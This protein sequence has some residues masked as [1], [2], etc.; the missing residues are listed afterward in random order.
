MEHLLSPA[1]EKE[2]EKKQ[3]D[4][5]LSLSILRAFNRGEYDRFQNV[6]PG[7]IPSPD[8]RSIIDTTGKIRLKLEKSQ[9]RRQLSGL[10]GH[11]RAE[12]LLS[13]APSQASSVM[14]N[15]EH[16]RE[17]GIFLLPYTAYGILNGGSATSYLDEQKNSGFSPE[18]FQLYKQRFQAI[19]QEYAGKAKGICPAL[20]Q[21]DGSPGPSYLE[22]KL[23]ALLL[24][25][26]EYQHKSGDKSSHPLQIFQMTSVSNNRE[27]A[28]AFQHYRNSPIIAPLIKECGIDPCRVETGIQPLIS[29]Y[30]HSREGR[31]KQLFTTAHG[32]E[33]SLLP[34][35]G[36]HG[37]NFIALKEVY[38]GLLRR[39]YRFA[40]LGNVDNL[41]T[42]PDPVLIAYLA[43]KGSQAAFEF[44]YKTAVDIKGG[45]LVRD[46]QGS[47][48]CADIGAAISPESVEEEEKK[49]TPI[50]FNCASGI[51]N[52]EFLCSNIDRIC[53]ELPTRFSDQNKDAGSYSQAEQVTWE[54]IGMLDDFLIFG[55]RKTERFLAAKLLSESFLTNGLDLDT[56]AFPDTEKN[57]IKLRDLSTMLYQGLSKKLT[58]AYGMQ[59]SRGIWR[60]TA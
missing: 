40:M 58:S 37:Q 1:I 20:V 48:T 10:L 49:G 6:I 17:I 52:L 28:E 4:K 14:L 51:F 57:G 39:G 3:I 56:P 19:A 38:K 16:L 9:A 36:G 60:P 46:R 33:Q 59:L 13:K 43:L 18:L 22:L 21:R 5:N 47:L 8:G 45:I 25:I 31:P 7:E 53:S 27:I 42:S 34:L 11:K 54:I 32:K 23:R 2:F 30:T 26:R 35:P 12:E 29:A 44:S 50:L 55:V 24:L 41:G 15:R